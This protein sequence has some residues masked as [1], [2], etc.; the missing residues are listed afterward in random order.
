MSEHRPTP[1]RIALAL[2]LAP[3]LAPFYGAVFFAEPR[4]L[5]GLFASYP[6]ALLLGL[7]G[8]CLLVRRRC[9]RIWPFILLGL[10]CAL[11]ALWVYAVRPEL[12]REGATFTLGN[13]VILLASGALSGACF[14]LIGIA[15]ETPVNLRSLF[16]QGPPG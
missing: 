13:A 4:D 16:D 3:A 9:L 1:K 8:V 14:W 2:L 11:P 5:I 7:P 15:G 12:V 6:S 10:V